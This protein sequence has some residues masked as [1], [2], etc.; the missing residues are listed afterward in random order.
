MRALP[1]V[2]ILFSIT[3][4]TKLTY[5][6]VRLGMTPSE[7][8]RVLDLDQTSRTSCG[9]VQ[10][11][12]D[13]R[14]QEESLMLV[15]ADDR[16]IAAKFHVMRSEKDAGW[17]QSSSEYGLRG[18]V[19]HVLIGAAEAGPV[20]TL[21]LIAQSLC[22]LPTERFAKRGQLLVAAGLVRVL[23]RQPGIEDVGLPQLPVGEFVGIAPELGVASLERDAAGILHIGFRVGQEP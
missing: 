5:E 13:Q 14:G 8:D 2:A 23:Q 11:T 7:Y 6:R 3:G 22:E 17:T 18:E 1:I 10:Y 12:R 16:R 9:L 20:D 4:C 19:D 21:R 15:I